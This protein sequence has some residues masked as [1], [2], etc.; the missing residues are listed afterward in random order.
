MKNFL[1]GGDAIMAAFRNL[2]VDYIMSSPGSE[3]SP[4]WEALARQKIEGLDGPTYISCQHETLAVNLAWGYTQATGRLQAVVLHAGVGLLQG[5]MGIHGAAV[6]ETPMIV[7]SG[8]ALTYGERPGFDPGRQWYNSLNIVGSP[9]RLVEPLVKWA[10]QA[11]SPET[12]YEQLMRAAQ[13]SARAPIGPT[14]LGVPIETM[15]AEW[16]PP[17]K[18]GKV[19]PAPKQRPLDADIER[20]AKLLLAADYPVLTTEAAGRDVA[21]YDAL[22]ALAEMLAI[23]VVEGFITNCANFPKDHPLHQGFSIESHMHR[24]DLILMVRSRTPWYPP[25]IGPEKAKVVV[26]DESPFKLQMV[27]Q[28]LQAD[29]FLD[30][31]VA[32]TLQLL[33]KAVAAAGIDK[34]KV[35]A[36]RTRWQA[37]HDKRSRSLGDAVAAA[38]D[39]R[40]IDPLWLMAAMGEALP[41]QTIYVEETTT[42]RNLAQDHLPWRG[43]LSYFHAPSGLGQGVGAA[44]GVKLANR[45]R[46]VVSMI[47][48]GGFLYN[49]VVQ[50]LNLARDAAL[51]IL[52]VLFNNSGYAAMK[53]NQTDYYPDGFG[54]QNDIYY[55]API[56]APDYAG[57]AKPFGAHGRRVED[58]AELTAALGEAMA[59]VEGG[60]TAILDVVISR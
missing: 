30:G 50:C 26:I 42:H 17:A 16:R 19:P 1:D 48:D 11:T 56:A 33:A 24:A 32:S 7:L 21:A 52:I 5:A 46:P 35:A 43:P 2:G 15:M 40:P 57:L 18:M 37:A 22:L 34:A 27:Y 23:P 14:Y 9:H 55:G 53:R 10:N 6:S 25:S 28:S 13:M 58:P 39:K 44:L 20:V 47:G 41:K 8:E 59:A 36:R 4:L 49:P 60:R 12:L 38:R 31:D 51:P 54:A 45:D 29:D 3:W